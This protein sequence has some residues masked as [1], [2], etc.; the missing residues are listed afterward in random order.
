MESGLISISSTATTPSC[1]PGRRAIEL[2]RSGCSRGASPSTTT[3]RRCC[4]VRRSG[5]RRLTSMS[6]A[7]VRSGRWPTR[8]SDGRP[9][10]A[11]RV[12]PVVH[13][14][15]NGGACADRLSHLRRGVRAAAHAALC[16]GAD[17]EPKT[18]Q[19]ATQNQAK[20]AQQCG[21][22]LLL[23]QQGRGGGGAAELPREGALGGR[24]PDA[25][26]LALARAT[27]PQCRGRPRSLL[28]LKARR[29]IP[30]RMPSPPRLLVGRPGVLPRCTRCR[31]ECRLSASGPAPAGGIGVTMWRRGHTACLLIS[32]TVAAHAA[33]AGEVPQTIYDS[34]ETLPIA[35]YYERLAPD[36]DTPI[37]AAPTARE[38]DL[39]PIRTPEL[40][41]GEV[42]ARPLYRPALTRPLFLIGSDARSLAWLMRQRTRLRTLHAIGLLVQAESPA[43]LA[44]V[45]RAAGGLSIMPA[46]A[47]TVAQALNLKH[48]PVLIQSTGIEQ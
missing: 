38:H 36:D 12:A 41:P 7:A 14:R 23:R 16:R 21:Q 39:L 8:I 11:D 3:R 25:T 10:H 35:P 4:A 9:C 6:V 37:P 24:G 13:G 18:T 22:G 43:D 42:A 5:E 27:P 48:Y 44:R 20:D 47:T 31:G 34:G 15:R 33:Y 29:R 46:S 28:Q 1:A 19:Q 17:G 32:M 45:A 2:R 40:S 26:A 30:R